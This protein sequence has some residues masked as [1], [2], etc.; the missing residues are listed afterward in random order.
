MTN[1]YDTDNIKFLDRNTPKLPLEEIRQISLDLY[2]LRGDFKSLKSERDQNYHIQTKN[3]KNYVF[4]LSN[5]NE[6]PGVIDF[7]LKAFS[8]IQEQDSTLPVPHVLPTKK[9]TFSGR[10]KSSEGTE[11]RKSVV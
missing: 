3:G 9:G 2:G 7:Q 1:R 10:A 6:N 8:H 5:Q 4:K 11:D